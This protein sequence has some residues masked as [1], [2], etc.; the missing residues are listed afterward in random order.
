MVTYVI[1]DFASPPQEEQLTTIQEQDTTERIL[2]Y[3][4]E[5]EATTETET[6]YIRRVKK[7]ATC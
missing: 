5:A 7:A 2:G 4:S 6:D 1:T 3:G